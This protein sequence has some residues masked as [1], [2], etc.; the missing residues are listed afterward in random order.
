MPPTQKDPLGR[1]GSPKASYILT[2]HPHQAKELEHPA[3]CKNRRCVWPT[4][5]FWCPS[6]SNTDASWCFWLLVTPTAQPQRP[7]SPLE[8]WRWE[9]NPKPVL[10]ENH[11]LIL[12]ASYGPRPPSGALPEKKYWCFWT[13]V[14]PTAQ[15]IVVIHGIPTLKKNPSI[16]SQKQ[17]W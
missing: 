16:G 3:S 11:I 13:L 1:H 5:T 2:S 14:T 6:W 8:I 4:S 9:E 15:P 7:P 12:A 10:L 17:W